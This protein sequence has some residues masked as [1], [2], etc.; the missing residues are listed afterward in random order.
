LIRD[1]G[2]SRNSLTS[3]I[4]IMPPFNTSMLV[5][6]PTPEPEVHPATEDAHME[7]TITKSDTDRLL[8]A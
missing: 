5:S 8:K 7:D 4:F 3:S 2:H 1:G 6:T